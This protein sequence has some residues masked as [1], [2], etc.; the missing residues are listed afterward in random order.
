MLPMQC[1]T[2][3]DSILV[4]TTLAGGR[5]CFSSALMYASSSCCALE[6]HSQ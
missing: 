5:Q 2:V 6:R 1:A 3:G 4:V